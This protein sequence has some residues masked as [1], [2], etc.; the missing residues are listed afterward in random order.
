MHRDV[1]G[2]V[3][4]DLILRLILARMMRIA[5]VGDVFCMHFDNLSA[6]VSGFRVPGDMIVD[7]EFAYHDVWLLTANAYD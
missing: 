4:L 5:L 1:V 7:F 6:D 2:L 3:A